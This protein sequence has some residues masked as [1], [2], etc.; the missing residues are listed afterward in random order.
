[1]ETSLQRPGDCRA[2]TDNPGRLARLLIAGVIDSAGLALGWTVVLLVVSERAGLGGAAALSAAMLIGVGLSAPFSHWLAQ[3]ASAAAT[4]RLLAVCEG[5]CRLALFALLLLDLPVALMALVTCLMNVLAWAGFAAMRAEMV[6]A[7]PAGPPGKPL[8]WYAVG[9]GSSEA[10]FAAGA[11]LA[12]GASPPPAITALV[13]LAFAAV[14][15]PTW[16]VGADADRTVAQHQPGSLQIRQ[17]APLW[18]SGGILFLLASGP[19][20][21]ATA[22]AYDRHGTTGVAVAALA[23]AAGSTASSQVQ[24]VLG[25]SARP[26]RLRWMAGAGMIIGWTVSGTGLFGLALALACSG[27][28]QCALEGELDSAVLLR[29]GGQSATGGLA[30][31]A[32]VRALGGAAAVATL[33]LALESVS[34]PLLAGFSTLLLLLVAL[35]TDRVDV[36]A[37]RV[38]VA[39]QAG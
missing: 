36:S 34:L 31:A 33:P 21:L 5:G 22:L 12:I 20:L 32:A 19:A 30:A 25:R 18:A 17:L 3:R 27:A 23:F 39:H 6:R 24:A 37:A 28:F 9:I 16:C 13:G 14:L 8:T 15:Y 7:R 10:V 35:L 38:D 4:L 11:S 1:M 2:A 26:A 29:L